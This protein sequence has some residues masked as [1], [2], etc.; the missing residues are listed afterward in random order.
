MTLW[1]TNIRLEAIGLV[2]CRGMCAHVRTQAHNHTLTWAGE[3]PRGYLRNEHHKDHHAYARNDVGMVLYDEL[4]TENR[5]AVSLVPTV[6]NALIALHGS[7]A[8]TQ[9][10]FSPREDSSSNYCSLD[11]TPERFCGFSCLTAVK[12]SLVLARLGGSLGHLG[13]GRHSHLC[14]KRVV[15]VKTYL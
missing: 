1:W 2:N 9:T 14:F 5:R 8:A 13:V 6:S 12:L 3:R 4:L 7:R 10:R 15:V 11:S